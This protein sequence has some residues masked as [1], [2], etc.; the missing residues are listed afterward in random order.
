VRHFHEHP[1][2]PDQGQQFLQLVGPVGRAIGHVI[3]YDRE[4]G[5]FFRQRAAMSGMRPTSVKMFMDAFSSWQR[6]QSGGM[7][8]E[9]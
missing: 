4:T 6:F 5:K 2:I 9:A 1:R 8:G 7:S 3:D